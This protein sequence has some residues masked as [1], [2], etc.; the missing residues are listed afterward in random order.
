MSVRHMRAP[1]STGNRQCGYALLAVMVATTL[2][3]IAMSVAVPEIVHNLKREREEEMI[4]RGAQYARAIRH[5]YKKFGRYP[6]NLDQLAQ[7]NHIRF[8]R[9]KYVDPMTGKEFALLHY[10]DM[11]PPGVPTVPGVAPAGTGQPG[12][13]ASNDLLTG[14][15]QATASA[16]S[17]QNNTPSNATP[18]SSSA[19][20]NN[21]SGQLFGTQSATQT[22]GGIAAL[23][24]SSGAQAGTAQ[25]S[26][27]SS[28]PSASAQQTSGQSSAGGDSSSGSSNASGASSNQPQPLAGS[29]GSGPTM[30]GGAIIGVTSASKDDSIRVFN[31]KHHYN[32]WQFVY[33]PTTD[34]NGGCTSC[35]ALIRHPYNGAPMWMQA[36]MGAT[37]GNPLASNPGQMPGTQPFG[38]QGTGMQPF[39][40]QGTGMQSFGPQG[41]GNS[42]FGPQGMQSFGSQSQGTQNPGTQTGSQST[43]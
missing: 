17:T 31:K 33:D 14:G 26:F 4:H 13:T 10:G 25:T 6:S 38:A 19:S 41:P 7:T 12:Q 36:A 27:G 18:D 15:T 1:G 11:K 16:A 9:R 39:G 3:L 20:L 35:I 29:S 30:G 34:R 24:Q 22:P 5:Y 37:N 42:N 40:A 21:S 28:A 43:F 2:L 32:E 8:L 23:G